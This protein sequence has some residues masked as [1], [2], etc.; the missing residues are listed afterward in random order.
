MKV[1][2]SSPASRGYVPLPGASEKPRQDLYCAPA[3]IPTDAVEPRAILGLLRHQQGDR[4]GACEELHRV[5]ANS[6]Q[7]AN[8]WGR[9]LL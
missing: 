2:P 5:A 3:G 1:I 4:K 7:Y 9:K 6:P 8:L